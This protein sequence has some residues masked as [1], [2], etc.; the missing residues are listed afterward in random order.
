[1]QVILFVFY[2]WNLRFRIL[3]GIHK[4]VNPVSLK[5]RWQHWKYRQTH[6]YIPR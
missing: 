3:F 6:R 5:W 1:M 4:T 2:Y